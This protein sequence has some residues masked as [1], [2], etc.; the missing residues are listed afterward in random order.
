[1]TSSEMS[2]DGSY[3]SVSPPVSPAVEEHQTHP[4]TR[5]QASLQNTAAAL[6]AAA[7][8]SP[9]SAVSPESSQVPGG[10]L[11]MMVAA[12]SPG[13]VRSNANPDEDTSEEFPMRPK[14]SW[15]YKTRKQ[16]GRL[17]NCVAW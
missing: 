17:C 6:E 3:T 10:P 9:E 5:D 12:P 11:P 2:I 14:R 15:I 16:L 4:D 7:N 1:M 13:S 8:S